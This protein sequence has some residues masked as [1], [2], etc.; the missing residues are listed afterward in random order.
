MKSA[1][2]GRALM[3]VALLA[4]AGAAGAADRDKGNVPQAGVA[5]GDEAVAKNVATR[6]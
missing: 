6:F 3:A 1:I 4:G 2:L 5:P